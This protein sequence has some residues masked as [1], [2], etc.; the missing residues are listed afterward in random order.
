MLVL[1]RSAR[2]GGCGRWVEVRVRFRSHKAEQS[3]AKPSK[4]RLVWRNARW[5]GGQSHAPCYSGRERAADLDPPL[6]RSASPRPSTQSSG[7]KGR[8]RWSVGGGVW[9]QQPNVQSR[10]GRSFFVC[11]QKRGR[12]CPYLYLRLARACTR[13]RV[14][15][16]NPR[17]QKKQERP[18]W[19][20]TGRPDRLERRGK[21]NETLTETLRKPVKCKGTSDVTCMVVP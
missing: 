6:L 11:A 16:L 15:K 19:G 5:A 18:T 8:A 7:C 1:S 17:T 21:E 13:T 14:P 10:S 2:S 9:P 12:H 3:P 20:G 4:A